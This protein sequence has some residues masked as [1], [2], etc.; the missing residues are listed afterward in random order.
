MLKDID[1]LR[2]EQK[3]EK[4]HYF[5]SENLFYIWLGVFM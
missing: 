3:Y 1:H 4:Y 2:F 5:S